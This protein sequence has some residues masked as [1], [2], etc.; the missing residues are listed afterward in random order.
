MLG[1]LFSDPALAEAK[2]LVTP[3]ALTVT[4]MRGAVPRETRTLALR[5]TAPVS[6]LRVYVFDLYNTDRDRIFPKRLITVPPAIAQLNID[7]LENLP[8]EFNL[9][10][11]PSGEFQGN[12]LL[13][14]QGNET[15]VPI[16]VRVK[17]PWYLPFALLAF[18]VI[19][20]TTVSSY[21]RWGRTTDEVTVSLENV[22]TQLESD[23]E[24]PPSFASRISTCL[25][26]AKL[27]RDTK[28]LESAR[29]L[30]TEARTVWS[31]WFR[32]RVEWL[33]ALKV[34]TALKANLTSL[35]S[36]DS[37]TRYIQAV[38]RDLKDT[39]TRVVDFANPTELGQHINRLSRQQA[40]YLRVSY[41]LMNMQKMLD[42]FKSSKLES[43]DREQLQTLKEK[44]ANLRQ[45]LG[46]LLPSEQPE[47]VELQVIEAELN[48]TIAAFEA[49]KHKAEDGRPDDIGE[50]KRGQGKSV[51][52]QTAPSEPVV[53]IPISPPS[54][55]PS[56]S[57]DENPILKGIAVLIPNPNRRLQIF[58]FAGY[59]TTIAFLAGTGFNQLYLQRPTFG[60][61]GLR[62]YFA[63]LAWGFGAEATRSAVTNALRRTDES[64]P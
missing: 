45:Q 17:D 20:G 14:Y 49:L 43:G 24:L 13:T 52:G 48:Q 2:V 16:I 32:Q 5:S 7:N 18:G 62:D 38:Q 51:D 61:D 64:K 63:L 60:A 44:T 26:D 40:F 36:P 55:I 41:Q 47:Q 23:K 6:N 39:L 12:L 11:A 4:G 33:E 50:F 56:F 59:L 58:S 37:Q 1:L 54:E 34:G 31:K 42:D 21:S 29:Q 53:Q 57:A 19:L 9:Q 22:R 27:A 35:P 8:V 46:N 10:E 15:S 30:I 25:V 3:E 28:Q